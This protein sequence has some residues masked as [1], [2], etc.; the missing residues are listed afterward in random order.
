MIHQRR[1]C[2]V[3]SAQMTRTYN[4]YRHLMISII[5]ILL[6]WNTGSFSTPRRS[7][8][9]SK[10]GI[11]SKYYGVYSFG[12]Q[13]CS[14]KQLTKLR[15]KDSLGDEG[16]EEFILKSQH[17]KR[18]SLDEDKNSID[19]RNNN[20]K[21]NTR[22]F[23]ARWNEKFNELIQYQDQYGDCCV[24]QSFEPNPSL[25][26]WVRYQRFD[27]YMTKERVDKLD[28]I[29]F[30]WGA[31][32]AI[33][34]AHVE[35]LKAFRNKFGHVNVPQNCDEKN[36]KLSMWVQNQRVQYGYLK[37]GYPKKSFLTPERIAIL[38]SLSFAWDMNEVHWMEKWHMLKTFT[39]EHGHA[40]VPSRYWPNQTLARWVLNQ[41]VQFRKQTRDDNKE[42]NNSKKSGSRLTQKRIDLLNS[43]EFVWDPSDLYW[44]EQYRA[45]C[46]YEKE[47]GH[48]SI[49]SNNFNQKLVHWV[50]NQR[51][52]CREY[53]IAISGIHLDKN[54][55][56]LKDV[57]VSGLNDKR[58]E[59]LRKIDFCW[60]PP[61]P[62][63]SAS[64]QQNNLNENNLF[65]TQRMKKQKVT[66]PPRVNLRTMPDGTK[67]LIVP[68]P[69]D[70]I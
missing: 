41:R 19:E 53:V 49:P 51:R 56:I 42:E 4:Q 17:V 67:K 40:N 25:G 35:E 26:R 32:E 10:N 2:H 12:H 70:E 6:P 69:W 16:A 30:V 22:S 36:R 65:D 54:I 1:S 31:K 62:G 8:H 46:E 63:E 68:F 44:W 3:Y 50:H 39:K 28:S 5:L 21:E 33:W 37:N 58:L 13:I 23:D 34:N 52:L 20:K 15:E 27:A 29:G 55:V 18:K 59:A 47:N 64:I 7:F 45:L 11:Y 38:E 9:S 24:P 66:E 43:L 60:L 61:L 48:C 14:V 57:P